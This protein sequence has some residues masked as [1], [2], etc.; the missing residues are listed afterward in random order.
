MSRPGF[1]RHWGVWGD[2]S[3]RS[4]IR[5]RDAERTAWG[6]ERGSRSGLARRKRTKGRDQAIVQAV[7][8]GQSMRSIA[9]EYGLHHRA[10]EKIVGRDAPLFARSTPLTLTRPW[11]A[12]GI[13]RA[14]WYRRNETSDQQ[15]KQVS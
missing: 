15:T 11:E 13:S 14:Q 9:R 4:A 8:S 10:V 6:R 1:W 2:R 7:V 12:E 5:G 3:P